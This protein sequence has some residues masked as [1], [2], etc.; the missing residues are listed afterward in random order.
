MITLKKTPGKDFLIL[1]ISDPQ[2]GNGEWENVLVIKDGV[3]FVESAD[4]PDE[5]CVAH[6]PISREGETIVCLPHRLV[7]RIVG[8][9]PNE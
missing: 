2:L 1:N 5:V 8:G 4:C 9:D 6:L 3:A 7:I